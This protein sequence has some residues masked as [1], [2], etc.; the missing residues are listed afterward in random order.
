MYNMYL[1]GEWRGAGNSMNEGVTVEESG[2]GSCV[3]EGGA[4]GTDQALCIHR[5]KHY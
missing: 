5:K 1:F 2:Q 4:A 3:L